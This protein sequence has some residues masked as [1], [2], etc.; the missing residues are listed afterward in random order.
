[1]IDRDSPVPPHRQLARIIAGRIDA[2]EITN[3]LPSIV[4]LV[5]EFGVARST[6]AKALRVLEADGL[7]ELSPGMGYFV[8]RDG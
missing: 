2:G 7:A 6:A 1:M 8:K 4:D 5:Q 3:R